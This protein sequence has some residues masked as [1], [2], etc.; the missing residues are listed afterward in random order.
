MTRSIKCINA[1]PVPVHCIDTIAVAA[2]PDMQACPE[3]SRRGSCAVRN[4]REAAN[5][6]LWRMAA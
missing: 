4:L 3:R 6:Y 1:R 5:D 2:L